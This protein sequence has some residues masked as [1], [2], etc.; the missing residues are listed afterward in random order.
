MQCC[1][2]P[3]DSIY[4]GNNRHMEYDEL[5]LVMRHEKVCA[6]SWHFKDVTRLI[7]SPCFFT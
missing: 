6:L 3:G 2:E 4:I 1:Y 5:S 7:A